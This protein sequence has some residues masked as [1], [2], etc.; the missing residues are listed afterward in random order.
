MI[1]LTQRQLQAGMYAPPRVAGAEEVEFWIARRDYRNHNG[2]VENIWVCQC[3]NLPK[4]GK[5][6]IVVWSKSGTDEAKE[7][8]VGLAQLLVR[9]YV[10]DCKFAKRKPEWVSFNKRAPRDVER[11]RLQ[12]W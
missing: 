9:K 4:S 7:E 10:M 6:S 3:M 11:R 8:A 12:I 5:G 1:Q 2:T